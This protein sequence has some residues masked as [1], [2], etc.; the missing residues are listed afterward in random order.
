M[1]KYTVK[2]ILTMIP[3]LIGI[4]L[5]T[6][7]IILMLLLIQLRTTR[8]AESEG[9]AGSSSVATKIQKQEWRKN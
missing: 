5:L 3:M 7:I 2:R 1:L 9:E 4:S 6:F 8:A